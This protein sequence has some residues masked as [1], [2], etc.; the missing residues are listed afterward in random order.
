MKHTSKTLLSGIQERETINYVRTRQTTSNE[1]VTTIVV[2]Q[3]SRLRPILFTLVR[4]KSMKKAR[5]ETKQYKIGYRR[6]KEVEKIEGE[7]LR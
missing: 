1:F 6:K 2:I 5:K 7:Q 3:G 4:D